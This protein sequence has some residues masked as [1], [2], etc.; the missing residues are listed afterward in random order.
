MKI[1]YYNPN[2]PDTNCKIIFLVEKPAFNGFFK[3]VV[4]QKQLP[5]TFCSDLMR[6]RHQWLIIYLR[7]HTHEFLTINIRPY[8]ELN[9]K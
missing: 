3:I 2:P 7:P 4:A 9:T 6:N 1:S 5:I 8:C